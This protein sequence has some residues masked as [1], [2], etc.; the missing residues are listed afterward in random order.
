[1]PAGRVK[2]FDHP[3][4]RHK[5]ALIRD[6]NTC[7]KD[8]RQTVS[9]IATLMAYEIT[10]DL[11]TKPIEINTP[12]AK[13][14]VETLAKEVVLVP[15]LR[16][17]LGMV[18]GINSLIPT[19]KV[20]HVGLYRDENTLEPHTYYAKFPSHIDTAKVLLLDPMLAT[21]GTVS[22]SIKILKDRG[23]TD[24]IF[25]G[26]VGAPEGVKRVHADHPDVDIYLAALDERLNEQGYIVPG[27]GDC[28]D[29]L[30]GT[31]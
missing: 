22:E 28:G 19:A 12:V 29:R 21:G 16:A 17:G 23:V 3:L 24:I 7:T 15:I 2:I 9:E 11:P 1:M 27:L 14:T 31:K 26:I 13:A 18:E 6:E 5:L 30:Y 8:F 10:R 4:I 25:V 20:G